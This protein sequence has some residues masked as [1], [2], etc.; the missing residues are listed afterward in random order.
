MTEVLQLVFDP[1]SLGTTF[2]ATAVAYAIA[3]STSLAVAQI[4]L[5]LLQWLPVMYF[6]AS[7]LHATVL[8]PI[9]GPMFALARALM[10][11]QAIVFTYGSQLVI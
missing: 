5:S 4:H 10:I 3:L 9:D 6:C 8:L 2:R 7:V 11:F 1:F